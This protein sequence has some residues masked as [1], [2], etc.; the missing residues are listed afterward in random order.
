MYKY[1]VRLHLKTGELVDGVALDTG[2]N[3][4]REECIKLECEAR[5][6]SG[7]KPLDRLVAL[8]TISTLQVTVD[9]PHLDLVS[10]E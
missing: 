8:S 4:D 1:P 6:E 5:V 9:N 7:E 2:Y 3:S 10:F